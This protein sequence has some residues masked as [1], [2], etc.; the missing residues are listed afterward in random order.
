MQGWADRTG[1]PILTS[2]VFH[3]MHVILSLKLG[4]HEGLTLDSEQYIPESRFCLLQSPVQ[5]F[6]VLAW[7]PLVGHHH[8]STQLQETQYRFYVFFL[9]SLILS[10]INVISKDGFAILLVSV[11]PFSSFFPSPC[12]RAGVNREHLP[13]LSLPPCSKQ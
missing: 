4:D 13:I 11:S 8:P 3:A 7:Q 5:G 6:L 1:D 12:G 10:T 9:I 2:E